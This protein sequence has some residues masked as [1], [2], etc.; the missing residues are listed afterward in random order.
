MSLTES[1]VA[2]VVVSTVMTVAL[3]SLNRA[4]QTYALRSAAHDVA[5]RMHFARISAISRNRDC[6]LAVTSAVS[7]VIEC[8]EGAWRPIEY[9][10]MPRGITLNANARPEFHRRGNVS[11]TATFTLR[12]T[13][14]AV[15]R[16]I[17]NVNGR[18][19]IQ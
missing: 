9:L 16:V 13:A 18:V 14:G 12:N 3:P 15:R 17:V 11:P 7:Y 1:C 2:A 19:R 6:R 4:R 5:S 10:T 8:D